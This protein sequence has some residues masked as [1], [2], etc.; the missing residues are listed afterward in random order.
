MSAAAEAAPMGGVLAAVLAPFAAGLE[1]DHARHARHCRW[2]LARGCDGLA[3]HGT[4]GE[5]NS[6]SV[7][8][9]TEVLHALVAAG[10][11]GGRIVA[12][13]GCCAIPDSVAL[14]RA[15]LEIGAAGALMLPPFYYKNV[16]DEGVFT[17]P[18]WPIKV[19]IVLGCFVTLL[20]FLAFGYRY[21]RPG[22]GAEPETTPT[23]G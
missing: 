10:I 9:R 15:A 6:L 8:E 20:Q 4:T 18:E 22:A 3:I 7:G 19:I 11:D 13:T 12:G 17:A 16:G 23:G 14:T 21:L 5:A 2:L 1:P